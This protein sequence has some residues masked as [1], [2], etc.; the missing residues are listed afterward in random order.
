MAQRVLAHF[1]YRNL[2]LTATV[3]RGMD[4]LSDGT[5]VPDGSVTVVSILDDRGMEIMPLVEA[6]DSDAIVKIEES[7]IEYFKEKRQLLE[8]E[9]EE[10]NYGK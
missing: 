5:E 10:E 2:E 1:N 7:A 3:E 8:E 6:L 9:K 4:Y